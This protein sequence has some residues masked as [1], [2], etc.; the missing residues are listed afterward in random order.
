MFD[1]FFLSLFLFWINCYVFV[2]IRK[3]VKYILT[4]GTV[5]II[6]FSL[7]NLFLI[8]SFSFIHCLFQNGTMV[9]KQSFNWV[10]VYGKT[11]DVHI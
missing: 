4:N 8:V 1:S 3:N 9:S 10:C 7:L 2:S 5:F 6:F 11:K